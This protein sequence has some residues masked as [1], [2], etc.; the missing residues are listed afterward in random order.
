MHYNTKESGKRIQNLRKEAGLTQEQLAEVVN[1]SISALGKIERGIQGISLDLL[2][3]LSA[4]F[5]V[6]LDYIVINHETSKDLMLE[7]INTIRIA[8]NEMEKEL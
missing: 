2:L 7:K 6:S 5:S 4:F 8:L 1:I 3:D